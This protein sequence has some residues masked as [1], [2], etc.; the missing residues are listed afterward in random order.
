LPGFHRDRK[1]QRRGHKPPKKHGRRAK[2]APKPVK[3]PTALEG[4]S[5]KTISRLKDEVNKECAWGR[6]KNSR[7]NMSYWRGYKLHPDVSDIS[8]PVSVHVTGTNAHDSQ[9]AILLE[10]MTM[11]KVRH[12]L[13]GN[14]IRSEQPLN[15]HILI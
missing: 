12:F 4:Q 13:Y 8:F 10:K 9:A 14:D 6:K 1:K 11:G 15:G 7:G 5:K 2:S 3:E